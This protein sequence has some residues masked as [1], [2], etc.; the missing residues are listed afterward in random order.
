MQSPPQPA[1]ASVFGLVASA[2]RHEHD[3]GKVVPDG[4]RYLGHGFEFA[5]VEKGEELFGGQGREGVSARTRADSPV[6]SAARTLQKIL[7]TSPY[8]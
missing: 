7:G 2:V 6:S 4:I 3:A 1:S 8:L 5:L